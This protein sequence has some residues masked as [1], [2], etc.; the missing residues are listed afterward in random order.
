LNPCS[1]RFGCPCR[2]PCA[3]KNAPIAPKDHDGR[4]IIASAA[5]FEE[6]ALEAH[7]DWLEV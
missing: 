4:N 7:L 2:S 6:T 5:R 1:Q 3:T